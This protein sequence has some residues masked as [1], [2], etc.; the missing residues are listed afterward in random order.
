M[1]IDISPAEIVELLR[2]INDKNY[3]N[4]QNGQ[5]FIRPLNMG[6]ESQREGVTWGENKAFV[7]E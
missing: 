3:I 4:S 6:N 2:I 7:F 5:T 1:I